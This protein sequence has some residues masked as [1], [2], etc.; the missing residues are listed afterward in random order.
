MLC[1][2]FQLDIFAYDTGLPEVRSPTWTV[3]I[4]VLRNQYP[5][6][7]T[8]DP[9]IFAVD[10]DKD[11]SNRGYRIGQVNATD[12]DGVSGFFS[13]EHFFKIMSYLIYLFSSK[14]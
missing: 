7:F 11:G 2:C 5:P 8:E 10:V 14:D 9:Y 13:T 1:F 12:R 6:E 3:R 4:D